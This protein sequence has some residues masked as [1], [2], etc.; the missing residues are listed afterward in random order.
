MESYTHQI[1]SRPDYLQLC[2]K[3]I[4]L[5]H[6]PGRRLKD[7][8]VHIKWMLKWWATIGKADLDEAWH[9][10]SFRSKSH[11][12]EEPRTAWLKLLAEN[13]EMNAS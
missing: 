1:S 3:Q 13:A 4:K 6:F 12:F 5:V 9:S 8:N 2:N 11:K 10:E 7:S